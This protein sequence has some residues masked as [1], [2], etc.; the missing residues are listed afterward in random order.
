MSNAIE[1]HIIEA[2]T[3][4]LVFDDTSNNDFI[5]SSS[6]T[7]MQ[8][9]NDKCTVYLT[10]LNNNPTY[11][12]FINYQNIF[13]NGTIDLFL[14][15]KVK[16]LINSKERI[17]DKVKFKYANQLLRIIENVSIENY[18]YDIEDITLTYKMNLVNPRIAYTPTENDGICEFA[19]NFECIYE[20]L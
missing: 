4:R 7:N 11:L 18:S 9:V 6:F 10:A 5:I 8:L 19:I 14:Y 1:I 17:T 16:T 15:A 2:I 3:N 20:R 12:T 13:A